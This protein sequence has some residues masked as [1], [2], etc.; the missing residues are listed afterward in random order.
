MSTVTRETLAAALEE[1]AR[2]KDGFVPGPTELADAPVLSHWSV[3]VLPGGMICLIG[4]VAGH[5]RLAD[6]WCTTSVVLVA[7]LTAGWVRTVSR[8]YQ[9]RPKLGEDLQ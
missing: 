2:I 3:E 8:Y 1:V 7:D 5:P 9:M 6:G 4:Q